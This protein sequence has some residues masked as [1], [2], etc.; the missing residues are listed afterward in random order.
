MTAAIYFFPYA[1]PQGLGKAMKD[2][3]SRWEILLASLFSLA[4]SGLGGHLRGLLACLLAAGIVWAGARFTL[5]RI[6]GLTGDIYGALN[7]LVEAAVLLVFAA[8]VIST[9][10]I[11]PELRA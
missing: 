2:H 1:R 5:R 6:P 7:E 8:G 3:T 11:L 4:S 9:G 10:V